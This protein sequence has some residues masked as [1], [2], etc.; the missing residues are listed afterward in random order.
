[1]NVARIDAPAFRKKFVIH[2]CE[3][4]DVL[5][6]FESAD[7]VC[8]LGPGADEADVKYLNHRHQMLLHS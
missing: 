7:Y 1:M 2:D 4:N 8:S 5:E 3:L 6:A